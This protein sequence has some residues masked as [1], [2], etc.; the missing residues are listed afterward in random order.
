[1]Q[2]LLLFTRRDSSIL[3]MMM[4]TGV[5]RTMFSGRAEAASC[6][7]LQLMD[8]TFALQQRYL[9]SRQ[10]AA[11]DQD[12]CCEIRMDLERLIR[13]T[14]QSEHEAFIAGLALAIELFLQQVL[15]GE[16]IDNTKTQLAAAQLMEIMKQPEQQLCSSLALCSSL[17]SVFWQTML[18]A[19]AA[20]QEGVRAFYI[21][22]LKLIVVALAL[23]RWQDAEVILCRYLWVPDKLSQAGQ[24]VFAIAL[25]LSESDE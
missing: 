19:I 4:K 3:P 13:L 9:A 20:T 22:R 7:L 11:R 12:R 6:Q 5:F 25:A 15:C 17:E 21:S 2:G 23:S 8:R 1:M 24:N 16:I 14:R 10:L 18:G